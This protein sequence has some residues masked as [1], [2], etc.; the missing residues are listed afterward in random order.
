M[1]EFNNFYLSPGQAG[2]RNQAQNTN[3][4]PAPLPNMVFGEYF[5]QNNTNTSNRLFTLLK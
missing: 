1:E 4:N 3:Q 5:N 2:T